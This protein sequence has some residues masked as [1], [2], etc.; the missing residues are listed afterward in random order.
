MSTMEPL[1]SFLALRLD[2]LR[3]PAAPDIAL[4]DMPQSTY[5]WVNKSP[6]GRRDAAITYYA[7]S[8]P[9]VH[10]SSS[11]SRYSCIASAVWRN[12]HGAIPCDGSVIQSMRSGHFN[13]TTRRDGRRLN[14]NCVVDSTSRLPDIDETSYIAS[15]PLLTHYSP[16]YLHDTAPIMTINTAKTH[17]DSSQPHVP[18]PIT[19]EEACEADTQRETSKTCKVKHLHWMFLKPLQVR[20]SCSA[21]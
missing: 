1:P 3:Y 8:C 15:C 4:I 9:G 17:T 12:T 21:P 6:N 16:P 7:Q 11:H 18:K 19:L 10:P 2:H 5:S 14:I 20:C 13:A